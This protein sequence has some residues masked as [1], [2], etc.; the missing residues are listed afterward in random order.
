MLAGRTSPNFIRSLLH[1]GTARDHSAD[2]A[3]GKNFKNFSHLWTPEGLLFCLFAN[4]SA[5]HSF[6]K[7]D[8]QHDL[9]FKVLPLSIF[10]EH[11]SD[12]RVLAIRFTADLT[13]VTSSITH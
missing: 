2:Q 3:S 9:I 1:A 8:C 10:P 12:P 13:T 5:K 4:S 11:G 7:V 6:Q